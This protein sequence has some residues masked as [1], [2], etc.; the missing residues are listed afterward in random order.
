[1]NDLP[2]DSN[3]LAPRSPIHSRADGE[4]VVL[5]YYQCVL[6]TRSLDVD[7]YVRVTRVERDGTIHMQR[8]DR[9]YTQDVASFL[10]HFAFA[11]DGETMFNQ[12]MLALMSEINALGQDASE[13]QQ[14]LAG[15]TVH[16]AGP[17][18]DMAG[19]ESLTAIVKVDD[20]S[21]AGYKL[22]L[23]RVRAL[24]QE[25]QTALQQKQAELQ[26]MLAEK[27]AIANAML[28]PLQELV[29]NIQEGIWTVNLYLGRD[30]EIVLLRDGAPA[31]ADTPITIRQLVLSMAEECAVA[32]EEGGINARSIDEFDRWIVERPEHL[33]QVLPEAKGVVVLIPTRRS[34]KYD[35]PWLNNQLAEAD[36][37]S[38]F[39]IR[40][41]EKLFRIWSNFIVGKTLVPTQAEFLDFFYEQRYKGCYEHS[42]DLQRY[43]YFSQ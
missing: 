28:K 6:A 24:A 1:M 3:E 7:D 32:A 11:P 17:G 41:G 29:E 20:R 23:A 33:D 2:S 31:P 27:M 19:M 18:Q 16:V 8:R 38:Y 36:K 9:S 35:D 42:C 26:A 40:N 5:G 37:Q 34:K 39:L 30:E 10:D 13:L 25:K 12:Q 22:A 14:V 43:R 4:Q 21:P 15:I